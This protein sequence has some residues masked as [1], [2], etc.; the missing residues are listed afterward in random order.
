MDDNIY[1]KSP[2]SDGFSVE[3]Y[4]YFWNDLNDLLLQRYQF[5][6]NAGVLTDT[7]REGIIILMPKRN[8]DPLLP[9]CYRPIALLLQSIASVINSRKKYYLNELIRP[10]QNA[11]INGRHIGDHI[12]L[13][14]NV[15]DLT[16]ANEIPGSIFTA[17]I[18]KAFDSLNW[19][20]MF[21]VKVKY[22]FGSIVLKWIKTF[23]QCL[24]VKWR[25]IVFY[26]KNF[27]LIEVL[28]G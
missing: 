14:F 15:I 24:Y 5:S 4:K 12:R 13:L 26:L 11:F 22:C 20:F 16:A 8:K 10:G 23:I 6:Y 19:D 17:D 3:F 2:G 18:C 21:R 9:S 28:T 27:Q 7:Q 25:V 1:D